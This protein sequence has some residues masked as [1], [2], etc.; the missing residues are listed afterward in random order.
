MKGILWPLTWITLVL[1]IVIHLTWEHLPWLVIWI[2]VGLVTATLWNTRFFH[3]SFVACERNFSRAILHFLRR[4][5]MLMLF[6]LLSLFAWPLALVMFVRR[7]K[8]RKGKAN[9][10]IEETPR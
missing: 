2:T 7:G 4:F 8:E 10:T 9:N 5:P 6:S 3:L 1:I